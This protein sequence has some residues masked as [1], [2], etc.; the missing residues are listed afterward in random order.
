MAMI[1]TP[2]GA[3]SLARTLIADISRFEDANIRVGIANGNVRAA[4]SEM[5]EEGREVYENSVVGALCG[6]GDAYDR[7][8]DAMLAERARKS[9]E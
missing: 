7:A 9:G 1:D 2:E 3:E 6:P 5:L 4:I 8:F